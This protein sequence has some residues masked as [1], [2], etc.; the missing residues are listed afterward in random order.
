M[1]EQTILLQ[2]NIEGVYLNI[3][4]R[5]SVS[6]ENVEPIKKHL[7][8][9]LQSTIGYWTWPVTQSNKKFLERKLDKWI[10]EFLNPV[11]D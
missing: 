1:H 7:K 6:N 2:I 3:E 11:L 9:K 5:C 10:N 8:W 4:I